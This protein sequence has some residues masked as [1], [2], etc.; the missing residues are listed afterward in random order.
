MRT[1]VY[2]HKIKGTLLQWQQEFQLIDGEDEE[3]NTSYRHILITQE[4]ETC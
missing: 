2:A 3:E 4:E 1:V